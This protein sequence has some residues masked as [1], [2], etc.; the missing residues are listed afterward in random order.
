VPPTQKIQ[1]RPKGLN[2]SV[3]FGKKMKI[4][5]AQKGAHQHDLQRFIEKKKK[6]Q[7]QKRSLEHTIEVEK[8]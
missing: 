7:V 2:Q 4:K 5:K 6:E 8:Q 1:H 3:T